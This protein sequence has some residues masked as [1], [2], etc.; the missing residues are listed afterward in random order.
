MSDNRE[1]FCEKHWQAMRGCGFFAARVWLGC[2]DSGITAI[3]G[4]Q[5]TAAEPQ[6]IKAFVAG[7][8]F[9]REHEVTEDA[10]ARLRDTTA[11]GYVG[12]VHRGET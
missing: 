6:L 5:L 2:L 1:G 4:R 9:L 12:L 7:K 8:R 3:K 10:L 11:A